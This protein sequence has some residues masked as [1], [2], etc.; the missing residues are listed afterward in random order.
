MSRSFRDQ[1]RLTS[2]TLSKDM[3]R[4]FSDGSPDIAE[5]VEKCRKAKNVF[6]YGNNRKA[7]SLQKKQARR[8]DRREN[9]RSFSEIE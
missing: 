3:N 1:E 5:K 8:S 2:K 9:N 4:S 6:R 7:I